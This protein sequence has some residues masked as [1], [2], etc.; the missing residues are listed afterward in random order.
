MLLFR[1]F[2]IL[3][4]CSAVSACVE[5][6]KVFECLIKHD[7][8]GDHQLSAVEV[9]DLCDAKLAWWEKMVYSPSW[10]TAQVRKDCGFPFDKDA[11]FKET[12]FKNCLHRE[13]VVS[14]MC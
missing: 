7:S 14:K 10:V 6:E 4:A 3:T 1:L 13:A 8:D 5:K 11:M 9:H 2:L 12:C